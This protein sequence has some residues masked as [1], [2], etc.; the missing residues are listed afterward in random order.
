MLPIWAIIEP[1][2]DLLNGV[3]A[4][5]ASVPGIPSLLPAVLVLAALPKFLALRL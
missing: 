1:F 2:S 5:L 4:V 3:L